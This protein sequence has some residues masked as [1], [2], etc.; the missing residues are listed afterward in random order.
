MSNTALSNLKILDF[1]TLLPGPFATLML[2]DMGAQVLKVGSKSKGDLVFQIGEFD[3]KLGLS[4]NQLWLNRNKKSISLNLKHPEAVRIIKE[5]IM[6]YDILFEQFR[7]GVMAKLGLSYEELSKINPRLIYCSISSYGNSGPDKYKAG[8]DVNFIAKSGIFSISGRKSTGP[9]LMGTQI[10]DLAGGSLHSVIGVLA[11]VNYRNMTG[12]GQYIDI[13]MLD[14]IIP[15]NTMEGI[16]YLA[17][18]EVPKVQEG[19]LN[20]K[21]IYDIYE[22]SD[23]KYISVGSLEPKFL[24][25]FSQLV[26]IPELLKTGHTPDDGGAIKAKIV[27]VFRSQTREYWH[28]KFKDL[29]ACI[30][31]VLDLKE[32]FDEDEQIKAREVIIDMQVPCEDGSVKTIRQY[33]MPI[34][35]SESKAQYNHVGRELGYDT[36]EVLKSLGY[37]DEE[38]SDMEEEIFA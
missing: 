2:A 34:K 21:G 33:A 36:Q 18:G 5:L 19:W 26:G 24:E 1:T 37:S 13:S 20:G 10:G 27:E 22:T 28:E 32:A 38:I 11:A 4:A 15:F 12:K 23:K 35:F 29:D 9:T 30:E 16:S 3:E 8:H 7:P 6:E 17:G 31:N 14:T 25:K